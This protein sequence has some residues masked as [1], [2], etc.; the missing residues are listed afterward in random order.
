VSA[1]SLTSSIGS[2]I[3]FGSLIAYKTHLRRKRSHL[4]CKGQLAPVEWP[5]FDLNAGRRGPIRASGI[6]VPMDTMGSDDGTGDVGGGVAGLLGSLALLTDRLLLWASTA[7]AAP[8]GLQLDCTCVSKSAHPATTD[9]SPRPSPPDR[10][11]QY[12]EH[13]GIHGSA[14]VAWEGIRNPGLL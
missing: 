11:P 13:R 2:S 14:P 6:L 4:H 5:S 12:L 8:M 7:L 9:I 10:L 1:A 3:S